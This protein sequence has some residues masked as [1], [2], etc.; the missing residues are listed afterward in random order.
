MEA[1]YICAVYSNSALGES[2]SKKRFSR[3]KEDH[4]D[5]ILRVHE[6]HPRLW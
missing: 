4:F 1:V 2:T 3:L 5:V 6:D